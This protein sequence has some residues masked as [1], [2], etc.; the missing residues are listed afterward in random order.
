[1]TDT[2]SDPAA[3]VIDDLDPDDPAWRKLTTSAVGATPV[4]DPLITRVAALTSDCRW[5]GLGAWR[6]GQLVGGV[7]VVVDGGGE[8]WPRSLAPYNSPLV[9][10]MPESRPLTRHRHEAMV[11]GALLDELVRRHGFVKLRMRPRSFDVRRIVESGW[12]LTSTFTYE[13]AVADLDIAWRNIDDNRRRLIRRAERQ[14]CVVHEHSQYSTALVEEID[15]L[16]LM[17]RDGYRTSTDLDAEAWEEA[18]QLLLHADLARVFTVSDPEGVSVAF[19]LV[20]C[21]GSVATVLATGADPG[22]LDS[23]AGALLRWRMFCS[24]SAV[25]VERVDLNGARLGPEGRFKA[26]FGGELVDRWEVTAPQGSGSPGTPSGPA[27]GGLRTGLRTAV[28]AGL[29]RLSGSA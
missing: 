8:V 17:M 1:M 13:V 10:P 24:L 9:L 7:A 28:G 4:H 20:T 23:G 6:D 21:T 14:G 11:A 29:R 26:S 12:D 25:G 19:M 5:S 16:H 2:P 3:L 18:L 15:R 27:V 22:Q